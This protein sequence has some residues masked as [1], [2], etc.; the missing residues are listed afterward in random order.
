MAKAPGR[1]RSKEPGKKVEPT[2]PAKTYRL[3]ERVAEMDAYP[4]TPT[5]VAKYFIVRALDDLT[6]AGRF[7]GPA[8]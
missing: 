5:E 4:D 3:L 8:T 1:P 6:R 7:D 2:I